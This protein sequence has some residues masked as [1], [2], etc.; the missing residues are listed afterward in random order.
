MDFPDPQEVP[1]AELLAAALQG[2]TDRFG[3]LCERHRARIWRVAASVADGAEADDIAQEA[4]V[5]A[6]QSLRRYRAEAPFA[7]WLTRIAANVAHDHR[8]SAWRRRV[9]PLSAMSE[10]HDAGVDAEAVA[11]G[12]QEQRAVRQAVADLPERERS[13]IWL[14]YFEGFSVAEIARLAGAPE[15][16]VRS[17]VRAGLRRLGKSLADNEV[18]GDTAQR[19]VLAEAERCSM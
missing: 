15:A 16:T 9:L 12:R 17:R 5:R 4:V 7:A 18:I 1:D 6:W 2:D 13:P 19:Q 10:R 14:H 3:Q 11:L 8:K